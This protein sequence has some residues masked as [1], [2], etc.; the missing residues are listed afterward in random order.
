MNNNP[1][2]EIAHLDLRYEHLRLA[3]RSGLNALADSI[4]RF[5]QKSPVCQGRRE[6]VP[7]GRSKSVPPVVR[8]RAPRGPFCRFD[9][10]VLYLGE[11]SGFC[12]LSSRDGL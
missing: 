7:A 3:G 1:E 5:G 2:I 8:E 11:G 6:S 9:I 4:E 12:P 10:S